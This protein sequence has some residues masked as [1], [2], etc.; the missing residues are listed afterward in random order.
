MNMLATV[1]TPNLLV[2]SYIGVRGVR[3]V[4]RVVQMLSATTWR[5]EAGGGLAVKYNSMSMVLHLA[6]LRTA[7][8]AI[9][10][11]LRHAQLGL[12]SMLSCILSFTPLSPPPQRRDYSK[13]ILTHH[14]PTS[15]LYIRVLNFLWVS[16]VFP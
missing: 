11:P 2:P 10:G 13:L 3:E 6:Y 12:K 15:N 4:I 16:T 8:C 9:R 7:P 14:L 5:E 1:G